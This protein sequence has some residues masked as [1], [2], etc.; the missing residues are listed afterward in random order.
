MIHTARRRRATGAALV[1][2]GVVAATLACRERSQSAADYDGPFADEVRAAIPKIE[3]VSRARFRTPPRVEARTSAQV[4]EFLER[5]FDEERTAQELAGQAAAYKVLGF[6]PDTLDVRRMY[7]D[8]LTEQ[9]VGFYDPKTKVL[10]VVA[11]APRDLRTTIVEHELIHAL[12]DQYLDLDSLRRA[13][14]GNNDLATAVQAVIEGQA[15]YE[16][17]QANLGLGEIAA[18]MQGGWDRVRTEIR[19]NSTNMPL[20]STAPLFVQETLLFPYL[21]GA[22]Y[23][24]ALKYRDSTSVMAAPL[25]LS[26]TQVMRPEASDSQPLRPLVVEL[27]DPNEGSAVYRNNLGEFE[28]RLLLYAWMREQVPA[29]RAAGGWMG[30]GY[31]LFRT[32]RGDAI[33]WLT[34]WQSAVDAGEFFDVMNEALAKR[35][36]DLRAESL[37]PQERRYTGGERAMRMTALEVQGRP[38]VLYVDV[39]RGGR[40]DALLDV[41]RVRLR[42]L[43]PPSVARAAASPAGAPAGR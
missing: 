7:L 20:F 35:H 21:S 36:L 24:R 19:R 30:D 25:P 11:D 28:T 37:G 6:L 39:P 29:V 8:L 43:V 12:Q 34:V 15:V 13:T 27:P 9:I 14:R 41:T 22:E 38:A 16:Q 32:P 40:T 1:A 33:A 42:E 17:I 18:R 26:T 2:L 4:R 23:V 31:V 5:Q 3:R 10:Y